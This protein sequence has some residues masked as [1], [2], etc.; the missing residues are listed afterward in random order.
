[1]LKAEGRPK[2]KIVFMNLLSSLLALIVLFSVHILI[3]YMKNIEKRQAFFSFSAGISVAYVFLDLLP[4]LGK[5]Q[6]AWM[7]ANPNLPFLEKHV[8]FLA[9]LGLL[10][11]YGIEEYSHRK[12]E[13]A[14]EVTLSAY[15]LF[16]FL[17][18]YALSS[19]TNPEI[20]PL[21]LFVIAIALHLWTKDEALQMK[22]K[23]KFKKERFFLP[24]ALFL[25][26]IFGKMVQVSIESLA[27]MVA[28]IGG[29]MMINVFH[30]ELPSRGRFL[31]FMLG[32]LIYAFFLLFLGN[33]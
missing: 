30:Y 15:F 5:G 17:I 16:N 7:A 31:P 25:G 10:F 18:G 19:P 28:F 24:L 21:V 27:L 9:L 4:K 11:F 20:R 2:F 3:V 13:K 14:F 22:D 23:I 33:K 29:G 6:I 12:K 26:W 1:M 8:Y 32:S